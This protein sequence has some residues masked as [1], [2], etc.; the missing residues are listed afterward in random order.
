[1]ANAHLYVE[2]SIPNKLA[3]AKPRGE[4]ALL[5]ALGSLCIVR[6]SR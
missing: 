4:R 2:Q 1:M 6:F 3:G 5:F